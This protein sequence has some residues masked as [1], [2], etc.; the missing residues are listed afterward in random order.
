MII[1]PIILN[2]MMDIER[3][4]FH[5][6]QIEFSYLSALH[7]LEMFRIQRKTGDKIKAK[8]DKI[9]VGH[10]QNLGGWPNTG[11]AFIRRRMDFFK[12]QNMPEVVAALELSL[13]KKKNAKRE[14]EDVVNLANEPKSVINMITEIGTDFKELI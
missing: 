1:N 10:V 4:N 13:P 5:A 9:F 11:E 14:T 3:I 12:E 2:V 7:L 8:Q 6:R